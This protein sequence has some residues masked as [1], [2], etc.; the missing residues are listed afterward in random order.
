MHF[1]YKM[2]GLRGHRGSH[3]SEI[4]SIL[5]KVSMMNTK[6]MKMLIFLKINLDLHCYGQ[7]SVFV[8]IKPTYDRSKGKQN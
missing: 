8:F 1:F 5:I 6:I 2:Y 7:P 3:F 4:Q